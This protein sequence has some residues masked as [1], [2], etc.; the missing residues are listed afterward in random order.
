VRF[1]AILLGWGSLTHV[2]DESAQGA[3][4]RALHAMTP[5]G[6]ILGSFFFADPSRLSRRSRAF[7]LGRAIALRLPGADRFADPR[8]R[9]LSHA[10][11]AYV[12][13][14]ER[15]HALA[16]ACGRRVDLHVDGG[17]AH[18]TFRIAP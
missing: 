14:G 17:Y 1:S 2:L 18:A 3:V 4:L 15:L 16:E 5:D 10:G 9:L 7:D 13:D 11:F 12:F 6:P 8:I